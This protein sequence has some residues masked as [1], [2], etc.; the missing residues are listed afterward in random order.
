MP[1][2]YIKYKEKVYQ[3]YEN[4]SFSELNY[5]ITEKDHKFLA[6]VKLDILAQDFEKVIDV[7]EKLSVLEKN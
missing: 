4:F 6:S 5:E 3:G 7:F 1:N 2:H